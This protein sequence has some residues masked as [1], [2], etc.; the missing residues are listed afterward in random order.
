MSMEQRIRSLLILLRLILILTI[1]EAFLVNPSI[2]ASDLQKSDM[3]VKKSVAIASNPLQEIIDYI[4]WLIIN[5]ESANTFCNTTISNNTF[6]N[7]T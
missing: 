2:A 1:I 3:A 6:R 4:K 5:G 7:I